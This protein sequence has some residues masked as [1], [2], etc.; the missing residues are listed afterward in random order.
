MPWITLT[1]AAIVL[2]VA[3]EPARAASLAA[4][5]APLRGRWP[6]GRVCALLRD[7]NIDAASFAGM[8]APA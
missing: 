4:L 6:D 2:K 1:D 3:L 7:S 8:L 5:A